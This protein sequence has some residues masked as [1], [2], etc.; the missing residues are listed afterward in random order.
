MAKTIN[1]PEQFY[2]EII[3]EDS[4]SPK[5]ALRLGT[6]YYDNNYYSDNEIVDI[7]VNHKPVRK[8]KI[9]GEMMVLQIKD[10]MD[11][12]LLFCKSSLREK[13]DIINFLANN[14]NRSVDDNTVITVITY[15]NLPYEYYEGIDD[16]HVN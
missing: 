8:A 7:R 4:I 1:W 2:N 5:I 10:L 16:P 11:N 3:S 12:I 15:Q 6:L 9:I 14:Y 13:A